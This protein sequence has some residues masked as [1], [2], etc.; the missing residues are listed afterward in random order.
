VEIPES[1]EKVFHSV[2]D[3]GVVLGHTP[4]GD[5]KIVGDGKFAFSAGAFFDPDPVQLNSYTD[6]DSLGVDY[7]LTTYA[8]PTEDG[9][10]LYGS[11]TYWL[12]EVV[13]EN[14][15]IT[16]AISTPGLRE[17]QQTIDLHA[18]TVRF[19]KEPMSWDEVVEALRERLPFGL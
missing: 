15:D 14:G 4:Y 5:V 10:W 1:H 18:I 8:P 17:L 3:A 11:A 6:L 13:D 7:L 12:S 16:F 2:E 19:L 9:A